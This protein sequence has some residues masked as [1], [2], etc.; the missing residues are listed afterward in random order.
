MRRFAFWG[1]E[2]LFVLFTI[3][4]YQFPNAKATQI[5]GVFTGFAAFLPLL[6]RLVADRWNYQSLLLLGAILNAI[7]CFILASGVPSSLCGLFLIAHAAMDFHSSILSVL[8]YTYRDLPNL[9]EAGFSIYYASINIR[10]SGRLLLS[11]TIAK[12]VSWNMAFGVAGSVQVAGF[13]PLLWY[14]FHH[15]TLSRS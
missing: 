15:K 8:G 14:L 3:E 13:I 4:Y 10:V 9:R 7:G 2:N 11:G 6:R 5:Y 1:V 12:L